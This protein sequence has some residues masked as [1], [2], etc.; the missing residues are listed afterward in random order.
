MANEMIFKPS[1][2]KWFMML[3]ISAAFTAI[4][5]MMILDQK[6]AGLFVTAFF[7]LATLVS[8][9]SLL[10]GSGYL[11]LSPEG[12]MVS[13]LYRRKQFRWSDIKEFGSCVLPRG[14]GIVV[15]FNFT[16]EFRSQRIARRISAK[17]T[18]WEGCLPENF[19]VSLDELLLVLQEWHRRYSGRESGA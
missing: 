13:S 4:G 2:K 8:L 7:G 12:F 15:G 6:L 10:P 1:R 9:V 5:V 17:L 18:D 16:P 3:L 14:G 19:G 11:K